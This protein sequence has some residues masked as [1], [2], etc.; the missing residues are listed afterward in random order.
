MSKYF[1]EFKGNKKLMSKFD[2][3]RGIFFDKLNNWEHGN[4][5]RDLGDEETVDDDE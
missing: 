5:F 1:R 3:F 2:V 4:Q